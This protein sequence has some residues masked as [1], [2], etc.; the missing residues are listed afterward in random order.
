MA[1]F[2]VL[3]IVVRKVYVWNTKKIY[4]YL[5]SKPKNARAFSPQC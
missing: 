4:I 3:F 2:S 1:T 5:F